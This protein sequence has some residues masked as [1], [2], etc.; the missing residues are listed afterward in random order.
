MQQVS[1][2]VTTLSGCSFMVH[3][4]RIS[5]KKVDVNFQDQ[6]IDAYRVSR[7]FGGLDADPGGKICVVLGHYYSETLSV[8]WLPRQLTV[9][10][11]LQEVNPLVVD[12]T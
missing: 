9:V 3:R 4:D 1:L 6:E 2:D 12:K 8:G 10:E 11:L 5:H 7:M